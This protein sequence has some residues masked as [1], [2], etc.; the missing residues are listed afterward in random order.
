MVELI[1]LLVSIIIHHIKIRLT[2]SNFRRFQN[3]FRR[4]LSLVR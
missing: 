4:K 1:D 2:L 3:D